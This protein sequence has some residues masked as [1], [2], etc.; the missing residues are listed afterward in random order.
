MAAIHSVR[1]I[2]PS[3]LKIYCFY[4]NAYVC[5]GSCCC[6]RQCYRYRQCCRCSHLSP[7]L[8]TFMFKLCCAVGSLIFLIYL[9]HDSCQSYKL[10]AFEV[11]TSWPYKAPTRSSE[12]ICC[13]RES[14]KYKV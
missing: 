14:C 5:F 10:K 7:F 2:F 12:N 1:R 4:L 11:C 9:F 6:C 8:A 3:F 13:F